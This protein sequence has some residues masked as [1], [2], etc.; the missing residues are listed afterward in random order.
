MSAASDRIRAD[1]R[2]M[3]DLLTAHDLRVAATHLRRV[4]QLDDPLME[5]TYE[6]ARVLE[7]RAGQLEGK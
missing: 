2:L 5:Q 6:W 1:E 3:L 7:R 4:G